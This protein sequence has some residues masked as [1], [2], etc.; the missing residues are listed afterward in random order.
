MHTTNDCMI[1]LAM[2]RVFSLY[3]FTPPPL[4]PLL[5]FSPRPS[6]C[7]LILKIQRIMI[8]M[9]TSMPATSTALKSP[10]CTL[11]AKDLCL[12]P[13]A[14]TFWASDIRDDFHSFIE[15]ELGSSMKSCSWSTRRTLVFNVFFFDCPYCTASGKWCGSKIRT[16]LWWSP[17]R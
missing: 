4:P 10:T 17:M 6:N 2:C 15:K 12:M 11:P 3:F 14:R 9:T 5:I 7:I 13:L 1:D 16:S 8:T